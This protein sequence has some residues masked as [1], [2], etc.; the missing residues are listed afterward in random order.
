MMI[1]IMMIALPQ[2]ATVGRALAPMY[3]V[4]LLFQP[5][6]HVKGHPWKALSPIL[7]TLLGTTTDTSDVHPLYAFQPIIVT[8]LGITTD[9]S[10]VQEAKAPPPI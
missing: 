6:M 2:A 4:I 9:T 1:I 5:L 10:D 3:L 7:V 8:L